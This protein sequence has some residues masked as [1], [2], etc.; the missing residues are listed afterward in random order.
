MRVLLQNRKLR[1][2]LVGLILFVALGVGQGVIEKAATAQTEGLTWGP[3]FE[4]DPLW[5]KPLPNHWVIGAAIGAVS[6]TH[7]TLPTKA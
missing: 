6:Y 2:G 5:P 7:L 4:V 3:Q 1:V